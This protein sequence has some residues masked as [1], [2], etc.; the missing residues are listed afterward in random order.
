MTLEPP[1]PAVLGRTTAELVDLAATLGQPAF[2]GRQ[3][4]EWLYRTGVRSFDAMTNLPA[5]LRSRLAAEYD[6]GRAAIA[7]EQ[8]SWD[9]TRKLLLELADG[10]RI[11][12]VALPYPDRVSVC[13]SSQTGCAVGCTFCATGFLGAGRNLTA[14]EIV[15][16]V[17]TAGE[18]VGRRVSHVVFMGMG[19]PLLNFEAVLTALRLLSGEVGLSQRHLTV[20]TVGLPPAMLRLAAEDLNVTLAVSLHAA[21]DDLRRELVP[22]TA[23][24][25]SVAEVLAAARS[26]AEM[27]GRRVTY[28]VV[29]LAGVND[30]PADARAL[31]ERPPVR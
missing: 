12:T 17:L 14:G 25:W 30:R 6:L 22:T 13:V 7:T 16:Q 24:R 15:D 29:L 26:Y 28:E 20:S 9:G 27:S 11:E 1:R 23:Q 8:V 2:R 18:R 10:A 19:E 3:L 31:A 21:D 4:A 5:A